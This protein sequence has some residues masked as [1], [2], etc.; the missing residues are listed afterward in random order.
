[1]RFWGC[2]EAELNDPMQM[3]SRGVHAH[4]I[5]APCY[6]AFLLDTNDRVFAVRFLITKD[7][8]TALRLAER[9]QAPCDMIEVWFGTMRLGL[10][11]PRTKMG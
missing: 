5:A 4:Q 11:V 10:I 7:H 1:M 8:S 9:I 2:D 6:R 3:Q